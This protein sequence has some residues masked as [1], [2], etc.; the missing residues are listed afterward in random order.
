VNMVTKLRVPK[1]CGMSRLGEWLLASQEGLLIC[2]CF[3]GF[4]ES[5]LHA[6]IRKTN[7]YF[8]VRLFYKAFITP[9]N[10]PIQV[11]NDIEEF[12]D[13]IVKGYLQFKQIVQLIIF[14]ATHVITLSTKLPRKV[15]SFWM[16]LPFESWQCQYDARQRNFVH[17]L[18]RIP[19]CIFR[20]QAWPLSAP[21][22]GHLIFRC[23]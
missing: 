8:Y 18:R 3:K 13:K 14:K 6:H 4:Y 12:S 20:S 17:I 16:W 7:M 2:K 9:S 15:N 22:T 21:D 10:I 11:F 23:L 1:N 5:C 19:G